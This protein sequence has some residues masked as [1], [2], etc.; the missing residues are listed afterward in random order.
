MNCKDPLS[1]KDKTKSGWMMWANKNN[2][3]HLSKIQPELGFIIIL[4]YEINNGSLQLFIFSLL[5]NKIAN[6]I[7]I[8]YYRFHRLKW[9]AYL[10]VVVY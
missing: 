5:S 6:V 9:L 10:V 1:R 4:I 3:P 8:R 2:G 7:K